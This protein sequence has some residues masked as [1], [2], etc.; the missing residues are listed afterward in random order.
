VRPCHPPGSSVVTSLQVLSHRAC[1]DLA[2]SLGCFKH[3]SVCCSL[4]SYLSPRMCLRAFSMA[5]GRSALAVL[6]HIHLPTE[7][8]EKCNVIYVGNPYIS[9]A[10]FVA[11]LCRSSCVQTSGSSHDNKLSLHTSFFCLTLWGSA[12]SAS[13]LNAYTVLVVGSV[14]GDALVTPVAI[15]MLSHGYCWAATVLPMHTAFITAEDEERCASS[16]S[17]KLWCR[18]WY[19]HVHANIF[20]WWAASRRTGHACQAT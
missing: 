13:F 4:C 15:G 12:G 17:T 1:A 6:C 3:H 8:R 10:C 5:T 7:K 11:V 18:Q 9:P 14:H 16:A 2:P 19:I 20:Q